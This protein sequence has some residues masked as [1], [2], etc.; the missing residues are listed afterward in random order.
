MAEE[1]GTEGKRNNDTS[2]SMLDHGANE[3]IEFSDEEEKKMHGEPPHDSGAVGGQ[4][5][6]R[7]HVS[8]HQKKEPPPGGPL[9]E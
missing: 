5:D 2:E 9:K 3:K 6:E 8:T 1:T 4:S 7:V